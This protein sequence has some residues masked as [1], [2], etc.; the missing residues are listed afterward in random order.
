MPFTYGSL[1][2]LQPLDLLLEEHIK[3][4]AVI[5]DTGATSAEPIP[6]LIPPPFF[7]ERW[8]VFSLNSFAYHKF[9]SAL[10]LPKLVSSV[11]TLLRRRLDILLCSLRHFQIDS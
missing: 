8:T 10:K 2:S 4:F 9:A 7:K 3:A 11:L 6:V 5:C 1:R